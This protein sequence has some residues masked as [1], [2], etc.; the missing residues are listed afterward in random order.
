[1]P[2]LSPGAEHDLGFG[3]DDQVKVRHAIV[4]EKRGETGLISSSQTDVR[5]FRVTVKNMH[6]RPINLV[7]MDQIP[8]SLNQDIK[9][10]YTGKAQPTKS[11]LEDKRGVMSY[12]AKLE[13]DEEKV[14]EY[15]YRISWPA[16]KSITY[17]R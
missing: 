15:G 7:L 13:P 1:M 5:N 4:E 6:E 3:L 17:D 9:I 8:V 10:D 11:N 16:A 12:E 2:L 14:F